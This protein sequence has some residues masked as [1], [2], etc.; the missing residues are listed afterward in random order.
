MANN[1]NEA[2][3]AVENIAGIAGNAD[4]VA[5]ANADNNPNVGAAGNLGDNN[6]IRGGGLFGDAR[7]GFNI[8]NQN[9][10]V[11][12][13]PG[14]NDFGGGFGGY[15]GGIP[16]GYGGQQQYGIGGF[17][18]HGGGVPNQ[19]GRYGPGNMGGFGF[20]NQNP[21]NFIGINNFDGQ[22]GGNFGGMGGVPVGNNV[23]MGSMGNMQHHAGF[24]PAPGPGTGGRDQH[25]NLFLSNGQYAPGGGIT[26]RNSL[27]VCGF[28]DDDLNT[29]LDHIPTFESLRAMR[30]EG[31]TTLEKNLAT[32]HRGNNGFIMQMWRT[33]LLRGLMHWVQ[34]NDRCGRDPS[35]AHNLTDRMLHESLSRAD[36]RRRSSERQSAMS[37]DT[38]PTTFAEGQDFYRWAEMMYNHL[39]TILGVKGI[40]LS[41]VIRANDS[42]QYDFYDSVDTQFIKLAPL[43]GD[44]FRNDAATVHNIII[45]KIAPTVC[46]W[47]RSNQM[48][49]DGR[50]DM[51]ALFNIYTNYGNRNA[52]LSQAHAMEESLFYKDEKV[53][54]FQ[55]FLNQAQTLFEIL[56]ENGQGKTDEQKCDF[57]IK[58]SRG[59]P[60]LQ[61]EIVQCTR[62]KHDGTLNYPYIISY[63]GGAVADRQASFKTQRIAEVSISGTHSQSQSKTNTKSHSLTPDEVRDYEDS[64]WYA[65]DWKK[66]KAIIAARYKAKSNTPGPN[67]ITRSR[68]RKIAELDTEDAPDYASVL[69]SDETAVLA[70]VIKKL[71]TPS[72][73]DDAKPAAIT[74]ISAVA[75]NSFGGRH[76]A[77]S[78]KSARTTHLS[79]ISSATRRIISQI[80][81]PDTPSNTTVAGNIELDTHADTCVLGQ[82]FVVLH[83]T[84]RVT[85]VYG[86]SKELG[87]I[88]DIPIV[89]GATAVQN[90]VTGDTIILVINEALWYGARM[91]HSL[92]NPNQLRHYGCVVNDNPYDTETPLSIDYGCNTLLDLTTKGTLIYGTSRT[93]TSWELEH[94]PRHILTS[95]NLWTPHTVQLSV[96]GAD[97][98]F[99]YHIDSFTSSYL[100]C[101][102][103]QA[104]NDDFR[105][106]GDTSTILDQRMI[107][108]LGQV[109]GDIPFPSTFISTKRHTDVTP[110]DLSERWL[111]GSEQAKQ[112]MESTTQHYV[113]SAILPLSRR[114]RTDRYFYR[115][116][117]SGTFAADIYYGRCTSARGN[118]YCFIVAHPNGF[119]VAYP[120]KG[121][122]SKETT[123]SLQMFTREWGIPQK[124]IV[125]GA[126]EMVGQKTSF[127]QKIT[128]YNIELH[129]S[130]AHR[131]QQNPAEG[132]IREIR[133]K[134]FRLKAKKNIHER[135]WDYAIVWICE[136]LRQTVSFSR[137]ADKRTPIEI[138]TGETPDISEYLDFGFYDWVVFKENAGMGETLL[139]R[140]IGVSHSFGNLLT[141]FV[142]SKTGKVMS[143]S[144]VQRVTNLELQQ[145]DMRKQ[146]D[147]YTDSINSY[148]GNSDSHVAVDE[149]PD[150]FYLELEHEE[151]QNVV[152]CNSNNDVSDIEASKF[153]PDSI[154]PLIDKRIAM[155]RGIDET[156]EYATVSKRLKDADGNPVGL[157]NDDPTLDNRLYEVLWSDGTTEPLF[158]NTIANNLYDISS[159]QTNDNL[160][161]FREIIDHRT[162]DSLLTGDNAYVILPNGTKR[163]K[164]TTQGWQ[165]CIL[166]QDGS[167]DWAE[168][169][170]VKEGY[171]NQLVEYAIKNKL[172]KEPAFAWWIRHVVRQN[173]RNISKVKSKYWTRTHKFGIEIP[174]TVEEA[175]Q[176]DK[177]NGNRL[178]QDAI[179]KEM[180]NIFPAFT[181]YEGDPTKL[182]GFQC[183][184][185]H[186][187]FDVKLGEN[188]RRKARFV[189]GGHMTTPPATLT[190]ASVVSR[191]SVRI[192]LVLA[193]L[194][195][196]IILTADIQNAYLHANCR[197]KIYIIAGAEFGSNAGKAMIITKALYGLKS[198]GAAFRSLLAEQLDAIGYTAS[199]GD[200]DV[201]L[202]PTLKGD[203]KYYEYVLVYVDDLLVVSF[204]P[205]QTMDQLR[206]TFKFKE[207]SIKTPDSFLGAQLSL[208]T[209][210]DRHYWVISSEKYIKA[211]CDTI[212]NKMEQRHSRV[213]F[214]ESDPSN[215]FIFPDR[216]K[217]RATTPFNSTYRPETDTTRE[218]DD[219]DKTFY[220]EMIGILRWTVEIGRCDILLEVSM[221]SSHLAL[222]RLG[223]IQAACHIFNYLLAHPN[224]SIHMDPRYPIIDENRFIVS[225][226]EEFYRHSIE[227]VPDCIPDP[228]GEPVEIHCFVDSSH[229]SDVTSRKS[230]TGILIF[231]NRAPIFW[232]S[233]KQNTV[234]SSTFGSEFVAMKIAVEFIQALRLKLRWMGIPFYGPANVYCDNLS[235]VKSATQPEVTLNKKHNGI[236]YH[237]SREAVATGMIRVAHEPTDTNLSDL[238]TK[239]LVL[240]IRNGLIDKFMY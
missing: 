51:Q 176:L 68:S 6:P 206:S 36:A 109:K 216:K 83:Y 233:K 116:K 52:R 81:N 23:V 139:G 39:N 149:L 21:R 55:K 74:T 140:F 181:L 66:R 89:T 16:P 31:I 134:W 45:G 229:A 199:R 231:L 77:A 37:A 202:R 211:A 228:L 230:Q 57:I 73:D 62:M 196:M 9:A 215:D 14:G 186:M 78:I 112:T 93:P 212:K 130:E 20:V 110:N 17:G 217:R 167:T 63:F 142:L 40:P 46:S 197:E 95:D 173:K 94:C 72:D 224:R 69:T 137:Y 135:L 86:Y 132:I 240:A 106:L 222:P 58:K 70:R 179:H 133:K 90:S 113:R 85:D 155:P 79:P 124:L 165:M 203:R 213:P 43:W 105:I 144:T 190:Y 154:D 33:N 25:G 102:Q 162:T 157:R 146:C 26:I 47:I 80:R 125:D 18:G 35:M 209:N 114:Y 15:G 101:E 67:V 118:K 152:N 168:M 54:S 163:I 172:D 204:N 32:L 59:C 188:F 205:M 183:I 4:G 5:N 220:Q 238:F 195:G 184:R 2:A 192:A 50:A 12:A 42:P 120:Q 27:S 178:W 226:W 170:D 65:M 107:S 207:G 91:E 235:V 99:D 128:Y 61:Q 153:T 64:E 127:R 126:Q 201:W 56:Y 49:N 159:G 100:F 28:R 117:L 108:N 88:R 221:L 60:Y 237:K 1:N 198:S 161:L 169:K 219:D 97:S 177:K 180:L 121:K 160:E 129:V 98:D 138:L 84:G 92:I 150:E 13:H 174:K 214:N 156:M 53:F 131:P 87:A 30:E 182:V 141:Y 232:Y 227:P 189:A 225:D 7:G 19:Y 119:C 82:N 8:G 208:N 111:I 158:A 11:G 10:F 122:S 166:W 123:D 24:G 115:N 193:S 171:P 96:L 191:E 103:D 151:H 194:N 44:T 34:D 223:H 48:Q 71:A 236:A 136:I 75:G 210:E 164:P 22:F 175:I 234:E 147:E 3:A 185:C 148:L 200:P 239:V 143:R 76:E 187:I 104:I 41:Y 218:L 38:A 145:E 29:L